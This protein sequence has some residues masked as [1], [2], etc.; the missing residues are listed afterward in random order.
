[1][2]VFDFIGERNVG[3]LFGIR[4]GKYDWRINAMK[5]VEIIT[6]RS[7]GNINR[8]LIDELLKGV[9]ESDAATDTSKH[10]VEIKIYRHT[11]VETDLSI[12]IYWESEKE[13][14]CES[15][16][17]LRLCSALKPWGLLNYSVWVEAAARLPRNTAKS[18]KKE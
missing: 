2:Q 16:L 7:L 14:Q 18:I 12:H 3:T 6:L 11:V 9:D 15:P 10:L 17:G 1:M 4:D 13:S 8:E 5:W